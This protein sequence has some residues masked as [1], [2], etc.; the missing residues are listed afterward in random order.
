TGAEQIWLHAQKDLELLTLNDRT[1]TIR[2]DSHLAIERHRLGEIHGDDHLTVHGQRH[3]QVKGEGGQHLTVHGSLHLEAGQAWLTESGRELHI[4][5]GHKVVLNA[6]REITLKAGGSFIKLDAS[7]VTLVGPRIK[8]NAG[9]SPGTGSGQQAEAPRLPGEATPERSEDVTLRAHQQARLDSDIVD[10]PQGMWHHTQGF[11]RGAAGVVV[12]AAEGLVDLAAYSFKTSPASWALEQLHP[13]YRGHSEALEATR[14]TLETLRDDPGLLVD[15]FTEPYRDAMA[16]G[17]TGEALGRG[18][19]ELASVVFA[20]ARAGQA[21]RAASRAGQLGRHA[22]RLPP[23]RG[24]LT[25]D[26]FPQYI[27][28][29]HRRAA[30]GEHNAHLLMH[31]RGFEPVGN[32]NGRYTPG[33][34]GIDGVYR[35]A[36]PPPEFVITEAKYNRARLGKTRDG[37]Q[38]SDNWLLANDS[39]RLRSAGLN[40]SD[41]RRIQR[42]LQR[43]DA[44]I[45]EKHL[46]RNLPDGSMR[47]SKL[48]QRG[49]VSGTPTGFQ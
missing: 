4:K 16:R 18:T 40:E 13:G 38:M 21:G 46:I 5:A 42:G 28:L 36:N 10:A 32:T 23:P 47:A 30:A 49:Y 14:E 17:E 48:N 43:G 6:G 26:D 44:D 33:T 9:G 1:E 20:P 25:P 39:Q 35:N 7:G 12:E 41:R 45:V 3:T 37:R 19:A 24:A 34:Q 15:A 2:R 8:I 27:G 22:G 31:E 29:N 11:A